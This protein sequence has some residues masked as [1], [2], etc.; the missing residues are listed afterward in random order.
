MKCTSCVHKGHEN[1]KGFV[2]CNERKRLYMKGL[3]RRMLCRD[4]FMGGR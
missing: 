1:I 2:Y 4:Y 3:F